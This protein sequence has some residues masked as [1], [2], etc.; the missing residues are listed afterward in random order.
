[1][2]PNH[3]TP[4][5]ESRI[6]AKVA[7][8]IIRWTPVG[9][10]GWLLFHFVLE[11]AWLQ[12][13][14][15]A[16]VMLVTGAW[17]AYTE[18]FIET[19]NL[20]AGERGKS[21]ARALSRRLGKV[22]K[23][24][25]WRFAKANDQYR[26]A[27]GNACRYYLVEGVNKARWNAK[28]T[29]EEVYVPLALSGRFH[30]LGFVEDPRAVGESLSD[31]A[32]EPPYIWDLLQ[33]IEQEPRYR[34]IAIIA[35]GGFGKTTLLRHITY[36]YSYEPHRVCREK[37]VPRLIPIL[38]YLRECRDRIAQ[39]DAPDLPT[40]IV[41]HHLKRL[42]S[43]LA[44]LDVDWAKKLL[45][46]GKA[47]VM[48]D[49]FDEVAATQCKAVSDWID[50]AVRDYGHTATFILTT[51]PAGYERYEG[52]QPFTAVT[53]REFSAKQR[54]RFLNQ[55]YLCQVKN[56]RLT[57]DTD[58]IREEAARE[59]ADL[60]EQIEQRTELTKMADNP[61]LLCM[62][63]TYHRVNPARRLPNA[64]P[65]LYQQFCQMLLEDR[66]LSKEMT[67][68]PVE[69]SQK[70][71]QGVALQMVQQDCIALSLADMTQLVEQ[72][73]SRCLETTETSVSGSDFVKE[74]EEVSEL[75][76][77]KQAADEYEFAHRSFQEY[78][79]SV[80]IKQQQ[81]EDLLLSLGKEWQDTAVLYAAQVNPTRLIEQLCEEAATVGLSLAERAQV[82]E[83][84][85]DCWL[86]NQ[87]LVPSGTFERLQNLC[88]SQLEQYMENKDWQE[89][90][91]YN[92]RLMIQVL[93]KRYGDG[94]TA[95]ELITFPCP[96]LLRIDR[97]WV[98]HSQGRFGFSV[99]KEI[100]VRCGGVLDG[101]YH[102][103]AF[104]HF[105]QAVGWCEK[106]SEKQYDTFRDVKS[107][108]G[109]RDY[110][111]FIFSHEAD[112]HLPVAVGFCQ[113]SDFRKIRVRVRVYL[114]SRI[115]TCEL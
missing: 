74:I 29:L 102:E 62:M 27:Q 23:D 33:Q 73:L 63:A 47:L 67:V 14:L 99:Q 93:G 28:T 68:M 3:P 59:A 45:N 107:K 114:F 91:I 56:D 55:W 44:G 12:S 98:T 69:D 82:L 58:G 104:M 109:F 11:Q 89:A 2:T 115:Q 22:N 85:Y 15:M 86:E 10:S 31:E 61:L 9:G 71:L 8:A 78:L 40:L 75:F 1:M 39:P 111:N 83:L 24:L 113:G 21:D 101:Q 30:Q 35:R 53:V 41:E 46:S 110:K 50:R 43:R 34:Q 80:E 20:S 66:P 5:P 42:S 95:E 77:R 64:R 103:R 112:G 57:N 54:D 7:N 48:L 16:P 81:R 51:R 19:F 26:Q 92:Y 60:I 88:Y 79:A 52:Q 36:R 97:L 100:Y 106:E 90:D 17:A 25:Q 105:L 84:A 32:E 37:R 13:A 38:L 96:D 76:V 108:L 72:N 87:R 18:N 65:K 94:F 70:V 49:G 6:V 4:G